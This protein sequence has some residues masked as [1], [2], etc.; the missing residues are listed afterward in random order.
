MFDPRGIIDEISRWI[1]VEKF[2]THHLSPRR[3]EEMA[4]RPCGRWTTPFVF[5]KPVFE[6]HIEVVAIPLLA[7]AHHFYISTDLVCT[8][9]NASAR[10]K[11]NPPHTLASAVRGRGKGEPLNV[12]ARP[13]GESSPA[14]GVTPTFFYLSVDL[15]WCPYE[16]TAN[17]EVEA[18]QKVTHYGF[19]NQR[20]VRDF[21][22]AFHENL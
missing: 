20:C 6:V 4:S 21:H 3:V 17:C 10:P 19:T 16:R 12:R 7:S 14:N 9:A 5:Q 18:S 1:V 22:E 11:K 13:E 2:D 8:L 15:V